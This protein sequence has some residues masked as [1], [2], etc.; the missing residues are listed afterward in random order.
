[1]TDRTAPR[2]RAFR[3]GLWLGLLVG[4]ITALLRSSDEAPPAAA[5]T[6]PE[7]PAANSPLNVA[8]QGGSPL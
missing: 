7:S 3:L 1:M 6:A 4:A 5:P 8:R 2:S